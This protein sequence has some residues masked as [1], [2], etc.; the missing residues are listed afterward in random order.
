M[1]EQ[2]NN[3]RGLVTFLSMVQF[4]YD[5]AD[6]VSTASD[7]V[8]WTHRADTEAGEGIVFGRWSGA[9]RQGAG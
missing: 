5:G 3:R 7:D 2:M 1:L 6:K 8:C 9:S 4:S